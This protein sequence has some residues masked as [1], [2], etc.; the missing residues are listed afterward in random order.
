MGK[1]T[2][3]AASLAGLLALASFGAQPA[4]ETRG[5]GA[6]KLQCS[7]TGTV[8]EKCCCVEQNGKIHCTLADKDVEKCC[9]ESAKERAAK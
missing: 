1:K 9:C 3:L 2:A 7:L 8:V 4:A 5:A 6:S